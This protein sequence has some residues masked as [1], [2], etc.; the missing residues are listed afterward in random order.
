MLLAQPIP[1]PLSYARV[2]DRAVRP[3]E[4]LAGLAVVLLASGSTYL[5]TASPLYTGIAAIVGA[6]LGHLPA[7]RP[8]GAEVRFTAST[9]GLVWTLHEGEAEL[10]R[11][12][13]PLEEVVD[14]LVMPNEGYGW[15]IEVHLAHPGGRVRIWSPR[16]PLRSQ[17]EARELVDWLRTHAPNA[18]AEGRLPPMA[19]LR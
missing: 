2:V 13:V 16:L 19:E 18:S 17:T 9:S 3:S 14:A 12:A 7:M 4:L 1:T 10:D 5:A 8:G 11:V 15:R 6:V